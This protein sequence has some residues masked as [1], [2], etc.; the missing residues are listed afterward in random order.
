M[1]GRETKL[2]TR[3]EC[4]AGV[5]RRTGAS[6]KVDYDLKSCATDRVLPAIR[7]SVSPT[8]ISFRRVAETGFL[9]LSDR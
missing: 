2:G 9:L 4:L 1:L 5:S 8:A 3:L 7:S 6:K